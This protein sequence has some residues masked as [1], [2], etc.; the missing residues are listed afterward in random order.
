MVF[1]NI[2]MCHQYITLQEIRYFIN[3][4]LECTYVSPKHNITG[5]CCERHSYQKGVGVHANRPFR[6]GK[7]FQKKHFCKIM[8]L[9]HLYFEHWK[10]FRW[11]RAKPQLCASLPC[12]IASQLKPSSRVSL[13]SYHHM[14]ILHIACS[15]SLPT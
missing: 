6:S 10:S 13:L 2:H 14:C 8:F 11:P 9:S 3:G 7:K 12:F 4:I 15:M 1:W 5:N